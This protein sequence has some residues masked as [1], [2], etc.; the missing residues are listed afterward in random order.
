M[1]ARCACT[2]A[3]PAKYRKG[4]S[5]SFDDHGQILPLCGRIC[6]VLSSL[7]QGGPRATLKRLSAHMHKLGS[8]TVLMIQT[9]LY[10]CTDSKGMVLIQTITTVSVFGLSSR[11]RLQRSKL[12]LDRHLMPECLIS[13]GGTLHHTIS[14]R[15][16]MQLGLARARQ[17][18]A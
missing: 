11:S 18:Q 16:R 14:V 13:H 5:W 4:G 9:I 17:M 10:K 6:H 15:A 2:K 3:A 12:V 7:W 8:H 1:P